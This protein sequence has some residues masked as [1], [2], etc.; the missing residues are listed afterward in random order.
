MI[1]GVNL[2]RVVPSAIIGPV[3]LS[4]DEPSWLNSKNVLSE[5]D[6]NV[7]EVRRVFSVT[8]ISNS[9]GL[10]DAAGRKMN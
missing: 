6:E 8:I 7:L 3:I 10:E 5:Y 9:D 2:M 1:G 4:Q